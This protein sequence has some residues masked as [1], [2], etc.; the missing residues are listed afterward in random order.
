MFLIAHINN[1]NKYI[2]GNFQFTLVFIYLNKNAIFF[3]VNMNVGFVQFSKNV[4]N[5]TFVRFFFKNL[6]IYFL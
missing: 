6:R 2:N 5:L 1:V 3:H 4:I